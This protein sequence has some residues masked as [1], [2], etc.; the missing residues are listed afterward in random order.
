MRVDLDGAEAD[1]SF[2]RLPYAKR[3]INFDILTPL[4]T[5][6]PSPRH[7][8][9]GYRIPMMTCKSDQVLSKE[10]VRKTDRRNGTYVTQRVGETANCWVMN[11]VVNSTIEPSEKGVAQSFAHGNASPHRTHYYLWTVYIYSIAW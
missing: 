5:G 10:V 3:L 9:L 1:A 11:T 6:R 2:L 7:T 4:N 8:F